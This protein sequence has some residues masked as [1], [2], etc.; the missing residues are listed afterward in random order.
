MPLVHVEMKLSPSL[1]E[2]DEDGSLPVTFIS[3]DKAVA[4]DTAAFHLVS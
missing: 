3:L 4:S 2:L 1:T